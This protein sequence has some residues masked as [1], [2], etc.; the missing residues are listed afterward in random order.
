M[1]G[2]TDEFFLFN[3]NQG[4]M[5]SIID[6]LLHF[7]FLFLYLWGLPPTLAPAAS[8][9][10]SGAKQWPRYCEAQDQNGVDGPY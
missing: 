2:S 8:S 7:L 1:H 10:D 9:H 4:K 6:N 3:R 5:Q